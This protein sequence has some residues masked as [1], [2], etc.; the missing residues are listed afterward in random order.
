MGLK[1]LAELKEFKA[2][3]A[4]LGIKLSH[5]QAAKEWTEAEEREIGTPQEKHWRKIPDEIRKT[6]L[7]YA[8]FINQKNPD[9][10]KL[11][12]YQ[13]LFDKHCV[14]IEDIPDDEYQF[15]MAQ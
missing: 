1:K 9:L 11:A 12:Q 13:E 6:L 2:M 8:K 7:A 15:Y 10:K 14:G 4:E 5:E 3:L